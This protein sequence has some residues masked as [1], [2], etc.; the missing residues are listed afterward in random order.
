MQGITVYVI[1]GKGVRATRYYLTATERNKIPFQLLLS[2][3]VDE[4]IIN[5]SVQPGGFIPAMV[6]A[7]F[8]VH[9]ENAN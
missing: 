9:F 4:I 1:L 2:M 5:N 3:E 6:R 7:G 8:I